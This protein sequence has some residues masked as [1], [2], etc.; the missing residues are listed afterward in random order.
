MMWISSLISATIELQSEMKSWKLET[1]NTDINPKTEAAT[2]AQST[3][4]NMAIKVL[5]RTSSFSLLFLVF[6]LA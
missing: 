4:F 5:I 3:I 2:T 6:S 1:T